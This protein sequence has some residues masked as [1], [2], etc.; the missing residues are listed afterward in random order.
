MAR[1]R[2]FPFSE[3]LAQEPE[4][5]AR[6]VGDHE[7]TID[8]L[9]YD[10][11]AQRSEDGGP[12]ARVVRGRRC[13]DR[14]GLFQEFAAAFQFPDYFGENFDALDECLCDM[15]WL[16]ADAYVVA[17]TN[18]DAVLPNDDAGFDTLMS[19]L[20]SAA[21]EWHRSTALGAAERP[22][23]PFRVLLHVAP[24]KQGALKARLERAG[25]PFVA[26]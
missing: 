8:Q 17:L 4:R 24:D 18:A 1:V 11:E 2:A 14:R 9:V 25:V 15:K 21:M 6:L 20:G 23:V 3:L 26:G 12:A 16:Q 22:S 10:A 19:V 7:S 5:W 13:A